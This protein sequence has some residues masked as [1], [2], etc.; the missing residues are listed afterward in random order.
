MEK[1][2]DVFRINAME[3]C[4]AD[5]NELAKPV[6]VPS[7][8][9]LNAEKLTTFKRKKNNILHFAVYTL[10]QPWWKRYGFMIITGLLI[11][12]AGAIFVIIIDYF[13]L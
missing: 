9:V 11:L 6:L 4:Y 13:G 12:L 3:L 8:Y 5:V 1:I 7:H 2:H 10:P